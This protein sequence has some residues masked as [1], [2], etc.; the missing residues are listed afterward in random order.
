MAPLESRTSGRFFSGTPNSSDI[1][2]LHRPLR[3]S[4]SSVRDA[5]DAS[6]T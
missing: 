6:V 4:N 2:A 3:M 5:L 1:S